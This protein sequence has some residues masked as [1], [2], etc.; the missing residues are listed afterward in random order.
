MD[1]ISPEFRQKYVRSVE[2][3]DYISYEGLRHL[4]HSRIKSID[5]EILQLPLLDNGGIAVAR[6]TVEDTDGRRWVDIG[7]ASDNSCAPSLAPHKIR[8][9]STRAKGRVFRDM[10]DI[11]MVMYEEI[12]PGEHPGV[13]GDTKGITVEQGQRIIQIM[14]ASNI[15]RDTAQKLL[16]KAFGKERLQD[17]T[18]AE[19]D[20]YI[21]NLLR[22]NAQKQAG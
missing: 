5:I 20:V 4:A 18:S 17:L 15:S 7:D 9:A 11:D 1:E 22:L 10:L 14:Q 2:G 8:L 19:A 3:R 21:E 6:A 13:N 16:V 12:F